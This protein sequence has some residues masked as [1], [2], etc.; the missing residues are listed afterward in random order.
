[1]ADTLVISELAAQCRIGVSLEE[2]AAPQPIWIDLEL[3]IDAASAA[4][5]DDVRHAADYAALVSSVKQLIESKPYHLME[6]MAEDVAFLVLERF[7]TD[8]VFVRVKKRALPEI[9]YAAI[10]VSRGR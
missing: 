4:R 7:A 2:Q 6:T 9:G 5:Q 3:E 10:E 8:H 1:M